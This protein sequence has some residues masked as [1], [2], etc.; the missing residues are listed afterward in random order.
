MVV[1]HARLDGTRWQVVPAYCAA[2][3]C[4]AVGYVGRTVLV[5]RLPVFLCRAVAT[6]G[7]AATAMSTAAGLFAPVF[8]MPKPTGPYRTVRGGALMYETLLHIHTHI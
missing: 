3:T 5:G 1:V 6:A 7:A 4:S 8:H 2:L